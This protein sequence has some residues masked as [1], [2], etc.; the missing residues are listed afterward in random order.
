MECGSNGEISSSWVLKAP[1]NQDHSHSLPHRSHRWCPL[2]RDRFGCQL[3]IHELDA[4][5]L[6]R[7]DSRRTAASWYQA[8]FLLQPLT[9]SSIRRR[10]PSGSETKT[11]FVFTRLATHRGPYQSIWIEMASESSLPR[12]SWPPLEG[13]RI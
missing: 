1:D 5:P 6:E 8:T 2:L 7:G 10:K 11:L 3:C 4:P 13:I 12:P 9:L